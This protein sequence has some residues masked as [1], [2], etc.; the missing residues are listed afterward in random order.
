MRGRTGLSDLLECPAVG[1]DE[2][3]DAAG[4]EGAGG[5]EVLEFEENSASGG[6]IRVNK[7][8]ESIRGPD[9]IG[10][11]ACDIGEDR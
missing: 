9:G 7:E 10:V 4:L 8:S 5:L 3:T 1:E 2:I 11:P 6:G